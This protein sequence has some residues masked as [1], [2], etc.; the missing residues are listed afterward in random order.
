MED[1]FKVAIF[2]IGSVSAI[3]ITCIFNGVDGI[4]VGAGVG[5]IGSIVGYCFGRKKNNKGD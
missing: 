5:I 2:G 1:K 4:V 3:V